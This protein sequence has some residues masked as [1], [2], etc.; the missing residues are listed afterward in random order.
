[1]TFDTYRDALL[2]IALEQGCSDAEVFAQESTDFSV[3][4]MEQQI[5]SYSVSRALG[6][7]VRVCLDGKNGYAYTELLEEPEALVARA[8]DNARASESTDVHPMQG[9]ADYPAVTLP[10]NPLAKLSDAERIDLAMKLEQLALAAD[11]RC[12]RVAGNQVAFEQGKIHIANTRGL[13]AS[14]DTSIAL[15][16]TEP[17]LQE[18]DKMQDGLAFRS[19]VQVFDLEAC[20]KEAA[21]DAARKF[22]ASTIPSG[23]YPVVLE[24]HAA[25][26]LLR[27]FFSLFS[28][29][30][31]QKGLSLLGDKV[32]QAIAADCVN[33]VDDPLFEA[34][35][36]PFDDEGVP[37]VRTAVVENGVL[38][39]LL[40]NLKTAAKA[41]CQSTSN[42]GRGSAASPVGVAPSNFMIVPGEKRYDQLLEDL[43]DGLII[44]DISGLH[45]G[46]NPI[47]G[48]FSLLAGGWL[49]KDGKLQPVEQITVA[50]NFFTLLKEVEEVGSDLWLGIPQGSIVASPSL[51]IRGLMVS[52]S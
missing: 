15:C 21:E 45:A 38:K 11:P 31:A 52:G 26:A 40:H 6:L 25:S 41:G 36:R 28:G 42:G 39:T 3:E 9:A 13:K 33:M 12:T 7:S 19:G 37:S 5:D 18:G 24:K 27:G 32:G 49:Q 47:S 35:P 46:L 8:M 43:G 20:A 29:E 48:D 30:A 51:K 22:G 23:F 2:R 44:R 1:M 10:E 14:R 17:V 50:G 16:Y 4:V 34:N